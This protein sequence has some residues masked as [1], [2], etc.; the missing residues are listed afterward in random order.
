MRIYWLEIVRVH[1]FLPPP[2]S[3]FNQFEDLSVHNSKQAKQTNEQTN[4]NN[5]DCEMQ[6]E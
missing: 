4:N 1:H 2:P 3:Q 5:A 6:N